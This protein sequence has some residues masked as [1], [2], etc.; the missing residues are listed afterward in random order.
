MKQGKSLQEFTAELDRQNEAKCDFIVDT[1]NLEVFPADDDIKM[2]IPVDNPTPFRL[3]DKQ[4]FLIQSNTHNQLSQHLGIPKRYY[5]TMLGEAPELLANNINHWFQSK[6]DRRMIRT[7]D[8]KARAYLSDR[9]RRL[10]NYDLAQAVLPVLQDADTA[11]RI[12]S[13]E[14]TERRLY[15]KAIFPQIEGEIKVPNKV[16]D[17]VQA[18][19]VISN[20]EIGQG[21]LKIEPLLFRQVN[22][23]GII[24]STTLNRYSIGR[25][26][27]NAEEGAMEIFSDATVEADN[28]AF[29]KKVQDIVRAS[30]N[31]VAFKKAIEAVEV[32]AGRILE[33][34]PVVVVERAANRFGLQEGE[35]QGI[36]EH[37]IRGDD[38]SAWGLCNAITRASQDV[39]SYDRATEMERIGGRVI[40]MA[41]TNEFN[42]F[43]VA[44]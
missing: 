41:Q 29:Y 36:L 37:L 12:E 43:A 40:E 24:T 26:I 32:A 27:D 38:M 11:I 18:G 10:D 3:F 30:L 14:V 4:C 19:I 25:A 8:N 21:S 35:Q 39:E 2:Q 5:D 31:D 6:P 44:A 17:V 23:N 20:S 22:L 1:R 9:Y 33:V 15:I 34:P 7:L 28:R 16:G 42:T 13:T